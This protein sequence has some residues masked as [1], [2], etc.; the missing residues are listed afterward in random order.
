MSE[1]RAAKRLAIHAQ[2][3]RC[4]VVTNRSNATM[5]TAATAI[6]LGDITYS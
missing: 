1:T 6:A 5:T 4:P 2:G 3:P